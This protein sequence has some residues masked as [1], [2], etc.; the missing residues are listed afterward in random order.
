MRSPLRILVLLTAAL[1]LSA[2]VALGAAP[3]P[4]NWK[5]TKVQRGYDLEF[6]VANGKVSKVVGHVL[7][8]CTGESTSDTTTF[9]P[10]GSYKVKNG[11]FS[12]NRRTTYKGG[13]VLIEKFAGRFTGAGKA[14]GTLLMKFGIAGTVCTTYKLNWTAKRGG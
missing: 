6:K 14:K 11:R 3:K 1:A 4:G 5:A 7:E 9:A 10:S 2:T 13:G 8:N 12:G